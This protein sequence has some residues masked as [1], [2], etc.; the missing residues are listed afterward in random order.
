MFRFSPQALHIN[1]LVTSTSKTRNANTGR[2][3]IG[4]CVGVTLVINDQESSYSPLTLCNINNVF[5]TVICFKYTSS[6]IYNTVYHST[7]PAPC[8]LSFVKI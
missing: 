7:V 1:T 2:S 8:T 6:A 4:H 5:H 3:I